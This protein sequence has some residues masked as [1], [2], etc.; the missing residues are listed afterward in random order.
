MKA[1]FA[2]IDATTRLMKS[3]STGRNCFL[4]RSDL[5]FDELRRRG[6]AGDERLGVT[7]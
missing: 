4:E 1:H 3:V 7:R 2:G 6:V 5:A